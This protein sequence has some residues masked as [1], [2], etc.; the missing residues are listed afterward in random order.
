MIKQWVTLLLQLVMT[1]MIIYHGVAFVIWNWEF[2]T[3]HWIARAV[4]ILLGIRTLDNFIK[5]INN[6]K[7]ETN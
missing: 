3:W 5:S 4:V 2:S 7:D 1:N 6:I